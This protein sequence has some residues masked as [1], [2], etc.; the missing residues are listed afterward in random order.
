MAQCFY[1]SI[2]SWIAPHYKEMSAENSSKTSV[3]FIKLN[4]NTYAAQF[5]Y[6]TVIT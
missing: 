1:F 2:N 6:V 3:M 4:L 5:K